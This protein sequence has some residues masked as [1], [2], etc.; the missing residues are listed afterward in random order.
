MY[1][2]KSS[3]FLKYK[4]NKVYLLRYSLSETIESHFEELQRFQT[5]SV[6]SERQWTDRLGDSLG[7]S[8]GDGGVE[9]ETVSL[10][11]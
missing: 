3:R 7:T 4:N 11:H 1:L 8:E 10:Y 2:L 5:R 6:W 9:R